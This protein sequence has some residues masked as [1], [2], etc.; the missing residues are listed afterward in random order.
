M[1]EL[2]ILTKLPD[3]SQEVVLFRELALPDL[4]RKLGLTE[5]EAEALIEPVAK[6]MT[7][8]DVHVATSLKDISVAYEQGKEDGEQEEED[9]SDAEREREDEAAR[10]VDYEEGGNVSAEHLKAVDML[11]GR[12]SR[13]QNK[14][15]AVR[16]VCAECEMS[17][18][19]LRRAYNAV[20]GRIRRPGDGQKLDKMNEEHDEKGRF[21][22]GGGGSGSGGGVS[23]PDWIDEADSREIGDHLSSTAD[24][25]S[26]LSDSMSEH[27]DEIESHG[28]DED[29]AIENGADSK[30]YQE[31]D[32]QNQALH[33]AAAAKLAEAHKALSGALRKLEAKMGKMASTNKRMEQ[34]LPEIMLDFVIQK[35]EPDQRKV[36]GWASVCALDGKLIVDKQDDI[37]HIEDLEPAAHDF[38]LYSRTQGDMHTDIGVGRLIESIIFDQAKRDAGVVAKDDQGRVIDGWW[39][40]FRVDDDDVW[41]AHKSGARLEFS[42]GGRAKRE[43]QVEK[44]WSDEAREAAQEARQRAAKNRE[45]AAKHPDQASLHSEAAAS[46]EQAANHFEQSTSGGGKAS[47]REGQRHMEEAKGRSST[48]RQ[49]RGVQ[50]IF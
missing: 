35:I 17:A 23:A 8:G 39:V 47:F 26:S 43:P 9:E 46:F 21:G 13:G 32:K 38:T 29:D 3:E 24:T 31:W 25:L 37:I 10:K 40:G 22:S 28:A 27:A 16:A 15:Y 2:T 6:N 11:Q 19:Q 49:L 12:L 36:F 50:G 7:V 4:A 30:E 18:P 33:A 34:R 41:E 1:T 45:L 44:A 42:I 20:H 5:A 14:D 48:A